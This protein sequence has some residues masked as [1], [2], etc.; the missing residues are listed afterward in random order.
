MLVKRTDVDM[1]NLPGGAKEENEELIKAITREVK[2]ETN[3]D[4]KTVRLVKH[5]DYPNKNEVVFVFLV[6]VN[7]FKFKENSEAK[8]LKYFSIDELPENL[9]DTHKKRILDYIKNEL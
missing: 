5:Y 3:A 4:T 2:E 7:P 6:K 9:Y 1:W 8:D